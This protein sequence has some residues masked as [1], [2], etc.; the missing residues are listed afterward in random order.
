MQPFITKQSSS[1]S[2]S[3]WKNFITSLVLITILLGSVLFSGFYINSLNSSNSEIENRARALFNS[4]V[5]TR[6]WN[7]KMG[8]VYVEKKG[9]MQSNPYLK[10][11]DIKGTNGK[12]Y[13]KKNP[14]LMTREISELAEI[15]GAFKFHIT[16]PNPLN[17]VN[18]PT[19]FERR[20]FSSFARGEKE[21]FT[22]E[23]INGSNY[24]RYMAPLY[25]EQS[26][27][28]C[29][30]GYKEGDLRG[31]I[32]ILFNIDEAEHA[33][34]LNCIIV[35]CLFIITVVSFLV[36]IAHLIFSLR[37]KIATAEEKIFNLATTDELTELKNRRYILA[38]FNEELERSKRYQ[39]PLS[40]TLFDLDFFKKIN[41]AHGHDIGDEVL[42]SVSSVAQGQCRQTDILARYGGEEFLLLLPDTDEEGA[43][44]LTERI[45]KSVEDL[46]IT[47][48]DHHK[49]RVTASFGV[50][51]KPT[52]QKVDDM[53]KAEELIKAADNALY[54][55]KDAGR[56]RVEVELLNKDK[57]KIEEQHQKEVVD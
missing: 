36:I 18:T 3:L 53:I 47:T 20:A 52:S 29:H 57:L 54:R 42:R 28:S 38:R 35:F 11:P 27:I 22:K 30:D 31:G 51:C 44:Y 16:S 45:R 43:L 23:K 1:Q 14:A 2:T 37:K 6:K 32:S 12:I 34:I 25:T 50:S 19:E 10:N 41:D 4:I 21:Q 39:R 33:F 13:T 9:G 7:A 26:C 5:L 56:N 24:F 49:L 46:T 55:A 8:G 48:G 15:G 17:P 40:C